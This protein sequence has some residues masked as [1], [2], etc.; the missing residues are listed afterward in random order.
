MTTAEATT[1]VQVLL[2]QHGRR[3]PGG[4]ALDLD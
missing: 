1:T 4:H 3:G 2:L